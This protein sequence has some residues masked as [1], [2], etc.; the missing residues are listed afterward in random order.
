MSQ[1]LAFWLSDINPCGFAIFLR[2]D[3]FGNA[4]RALGIEDK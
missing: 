1:K 4:E 3:M 2:C